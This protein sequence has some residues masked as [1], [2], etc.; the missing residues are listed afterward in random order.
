MNNTAETKRMAM[1]KAKAISKV[2]LEKM[3]RG[4]LSKIDPETQEMVYMKTYKQLLLDPNF[5]LQHNEE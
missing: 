5:S 4:N 2:I 3:S 1:I